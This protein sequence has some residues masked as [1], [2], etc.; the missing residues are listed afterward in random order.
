MVTVLSPQSLMKTIRPPRA[1]SPR[2]MTLIE[3]TAVL[4][5]LLMLLSL[6]FLGARAWKNGSDRAGC[7]LTL[8]NIQVAVRSYQ[9]SY[10]FQPG[11]TP[12]PS[13]GSSDIARLLL[14]RDYLTSSCYEAVT[15]ASPCVGGGFYQ[16]TDASVFPQ[17]G[18]LYAQC[19]LMNTGRHCPDAYDSW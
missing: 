1:S 4:G 18:V 13:N 2:G 12:A 9:N 14:D 8:R 16:R 15:G 7:V 10:G 11:D 19:S 6:L 5:V 17:V 3:T